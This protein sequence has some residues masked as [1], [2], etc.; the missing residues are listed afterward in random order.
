MIALTLAEIAAIA[1]GALD[2]AA[3]PAAPTAPVTGPVVID[4]PR[5]SPGAPFAALPREHVDGHDF[6]PAA[7][8]AG[9]AAVLA[10]RPLPEGAGVPAIVVP[11]VTAA[12]AV[13][14]AAVLG[15]LPAVTVVGITGS[16][17]KTSTK[18][19]LAQLAERLGPTVAPEGSFNNELGLPL[20]VLRADEQ[21]KYLVLE[22]SARGA[23]LNVGRVHAGEFGSL[24]GVAKANG[25]L[26]EALPADGVAVLNAD[27]PR[28][29]A[30][31]DRPRPGSSRSPSGRPPTPW[32]G[33]RTSGSTTSGGPASPC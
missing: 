4:S 9:A 21:T 5:V 27:D 32:C 24:D 31:A 11:D 30:M 12:L 10:S 22:M 7:A 26:P 1:G 14:A 15:R 33:R 6:A 17:G 18:D 2:P 28:V 8:A 13:L 16:S 29:L 25:E 19:L 20:T 3:G 23:V